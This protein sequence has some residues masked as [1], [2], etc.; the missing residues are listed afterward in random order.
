MQA[1][2]NF[3]SAC[4]RT[5]FHVVPFGDMPLVNR[6]P[7]GSCCR[8]LHGRGFRRAHFVASGRGCA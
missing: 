2:S 3:L 5:V 8:R 7:V 6:S 1:E 4:A